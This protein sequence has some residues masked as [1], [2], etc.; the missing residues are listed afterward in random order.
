MY[1]NL[2][3][4]VYTDGLQRPLVYTPALK[5]LYIFSPDGGLQRQKLVATILV[6][7]IQNSCV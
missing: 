1:K 6:N 5:F 7:K 4:G 2:N 3:A